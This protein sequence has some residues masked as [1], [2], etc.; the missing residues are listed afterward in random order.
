MLTRDNKKL[1]YRRGTARRAT[2]AEMTLSDIHRQSTH[3]STVV[4][5]L[6][7]DFSYICAAVDKISTDT[8]RRAVPLRQ[9]SFLFNLPK[10]SLLNFNASYSVVLYD[11]NSNSPK[12]AAGIFLRPSSGVGYLTPYASPTPTLKM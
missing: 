8:E 3:L 9:L 4:G 1:S 7:W 2:S 11:E 10:Q 5:L 6:N 12:R